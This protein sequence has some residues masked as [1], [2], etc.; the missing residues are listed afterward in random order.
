MVIYVS[1]CNLIWNNIF[2]ILP[3]LSPHLL[4]NPLMNFHNLDLQKLISHQNVLYLQQPPPQLQ[5][6]PWSS[7]LLDVTVNLC[8]EHIKCQVIQ[9][10]YRLYAHILPASTHNTWINLLSTVK[11]YPTTITIS[12]SSITGHNKFTHKIRGIFACVSSDIYHYL[13]SIPFWIL[14]RTNGTNF[15]QND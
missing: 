5:L 2:S 7:K 11:F 9:K 3:S 13:P 14:G 1:I 12:S 8:N 4:E 15:V 10:I 6:Q